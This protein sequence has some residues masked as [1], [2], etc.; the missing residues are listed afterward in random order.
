MHQEN[1]GPAKA[2]NKALAEAKGKYADSLKS[3]GRYE[4]AINVYKELSGKDNEI[5]IHMIN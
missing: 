3:E 4:E 5:T 1:S 2:R